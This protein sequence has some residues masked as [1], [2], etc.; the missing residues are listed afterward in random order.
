MDCDTAIAMPPPKDSRE[1]TFMREYVMSPVAADDTTLEQIPMKKSEAPLKAASHNAV[2]RLI[3][4]EFLD[5]P[6]Q[7]KL[8]SITSDFIDATGNEALKTVPC[9]SC[10]REMNRSECNETTLK[11]IPNR[12]HLIPHAAHPAHK[13]VDGLLIYPP[14]MGS[15]RKTCHLCNECRNQ[16]KK[17]LCP[18]LSLS[19]GMWIGEVPQQLQ[20]L[21]L[22]ERIMIAKYFPSAYIVKLFPKHK[23]AF[24]WDR[25]QMHNGLKGN[26]STYRLDPRQVATMIDGRTYPPPARILSAT[27]GITFIG[28]KG[29]REPTMPA[30]FRVRRWKIKEALTWLKPNNPLY[31]DIEISEERLLQ[32]PEDGIPDELSMTAKYSTDTEAVEREHGGYVPTDAADD[33][34]G[35]YTIYNY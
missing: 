27:I 30:M 10:A 14:A 28:P 18:R 8:N 3:A 29:Y 5:T 17:N 33:N 12:H 16:L 24:T 13:L 23:N 35:D 34:E 26:V 2:E 1:W 19:N 11:D 4:S 31:A 22:P 21:T 15:S 20:N 25:S 7:E 6:S 9:G 32:L